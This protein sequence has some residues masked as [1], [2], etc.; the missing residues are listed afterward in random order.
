MSRARRRNRSHLYVTRGIYMYYCTGGSLAVYR[1]TKGKEV[2]VSEVPFSAASCTG[3]TTCWPFPPSSFSSIL[4]ISPQFFHFGRRCSL[5]FLCTWTYVFRSRYKQIET[6]K[7][8][9][10]IK[11]WPKVQIQ[12]KEREVE[13]SDDRHVH[14]TSQSG[15]GRVLLVFS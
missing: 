12:R 1:K 9:K 6:R 13:R 10:R 5:H 3:A 7:K 11:R 14:V 2:R 4:V 8:K 15:P